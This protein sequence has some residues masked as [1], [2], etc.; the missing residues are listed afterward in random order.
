MTSSIG[1]FG[2]LLIA[3][4]AWGVGYYVS[5]LFDESSPTYYSLLTLIDL[6]FI[7]IVAWSTISNMHKRYMS[8]ILLIAVIMSFMAM[9]TDVLYALVGASNSF[10][11]AVYY[12]AL[13]W[14]ANYSYLSIILSVLLFTVSITPKGILNVIDTRIWPS[15]LSGVYCVYGANRMEDSKKGLWDSRRE[16]EN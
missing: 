8:T 5:G 12:A 7:L 2:A 3:S 14:D 1:K 13:L 4:I 10:F 15:A 11:S 6:V 16:G 9:L